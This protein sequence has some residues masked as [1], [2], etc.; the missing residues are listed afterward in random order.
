MIMRRLR[1]YVAISTIFWRARTAFMGNLV[2]QGLLTSLYAWMNNQLYAATFV[3]CNAETI[4]G[5]NL[6]QTIWLIAIAQ[7]FERASMPSPISVIDDEIKTGLITYSLQRPYS[8]IL[9]H[10]F[11]FFGRVAAS[12]SINL[13]CTSIALLFLVGMCPCSIPSLLAGA[14]CLMLGCL[15]DFFAFFIFGL[16][17]FWVED[18]KPFNWL[19]SKTKLIFGGIIIP[20][21]FFPHAV[22]HVAKFLPFGYLYYT[23]CSLI[24]NFD[25][26]LFI[27]CLVTQLCWTALFGGL[28]C[29]VFSRGVRHVAINGG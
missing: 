10:L 19:Y 11:G 12:V 2:M 16:M 3:V 14:L 15:L 23:A 7:C 22:Q 28:A 24:V 27:Q 8:Y 29:Y 1:A 18:V 13:L 6:S 25:I 9:Y 17:G 5:F 21:A 4:G 26:S 20:L